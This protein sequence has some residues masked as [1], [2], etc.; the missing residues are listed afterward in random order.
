MMFDVPNMYSSKD[1]NF[2]QQVLEDAVNALP[3]Q[4]RTS[5]SKARIAKRLLDCAAS[6]ERN[7]KKLRVAGLADFAEQAKSA[8]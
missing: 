6:G 8:A 1:L 4:M 3:L 5:V 7:R 2:L